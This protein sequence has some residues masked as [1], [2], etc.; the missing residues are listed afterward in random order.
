METPWPVETADL[1][2]IAGTTEG[3]NYF[4]SRRN[5]VLASLSGPRACREQGKEHFPVFR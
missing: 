1:Y 3:T 2:E 4:Y 5:A